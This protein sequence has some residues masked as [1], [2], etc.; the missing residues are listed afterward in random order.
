[1]NSNMLLQ[2][3]TQLGESTFEAAISVS[4]AMRKRLN[5]MTA[6]KLISNPS[7]EIMLYID[8][9]S[10]D[11]TIGGVAFARSATDKDLSYIFATTSPDAD[12]MKPVT[13]QRYP[14]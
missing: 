6:P 11:H 5:S 2:M 12:M 9:R 13:Q 3:M 8:S 1:M 14:M 4:I 10:G 7:D